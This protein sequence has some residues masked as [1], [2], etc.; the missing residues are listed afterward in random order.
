MMRSKG[1]SKKPNA[2]RSPNRS[3]IKLAL[4]SAAQ[5]RAANPA[6][7]LFEVGDVARVPQ[8]SDGSAAHFRAKS[9]VSSAGSFSGLTMA[10]SRRR[11]V[12]IATPTVLAGSLATRQRAPRAESHPG[13]CIFCPG[14]ATPK[15]TGRAFDRF[16]LL[17]REPTV[18]SQLTKRPRRFKW[19]LSK[20]IRGWRRRCDRAADSR[21]YRIGRHRTRFR[22][23]P[24]RRR[25]PPSK[26][27]S[28]SDPS[29]VVGQ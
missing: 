15:A 2:A 11:R 18:R 8:R 4:A 21:W 3:L 29:P 24:E 25:F 12:T 9:N 23:E 28:R 17:R 6:V 5:R 26:A 14:P 7:G 16:K 27:S 1:G 10:R 22:A 20:S 13:T 19:A